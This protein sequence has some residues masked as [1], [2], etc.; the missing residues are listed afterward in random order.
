MG[1]G[2]ARRNDRRRQLDKRVLR[3]VDV[4]GETHAEDVLVVRTTE[5]F[6]DERA[7]LEVVRGTRLIE[8]VPLEA[9][10]LERDGRGDPRLDRAVVVEPPLEEV[11]VVADDR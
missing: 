7:P 1:A 10:G 5:P 4:H 2:E 9:L 6:V 8:V 11:V 3:T